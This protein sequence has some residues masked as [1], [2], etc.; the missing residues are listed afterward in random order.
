MAFA[1]HN[2]DNPPASSPLV[3]L[4]GTLCDAR[5]FAPMLQRLPP[6][7]VLH[8]PLDGGEDV[9]AVASRILDRAPPTFALMGF[10]L[11][12]IVALEILRRAPDRLIGLALI[13][14]TARPVPAEQR[15]A[16]RAGNALAAHER[17]EHLI[18][19]L[20]PE[21]VG[22]GS[23]RDAALRRTIVAMAT[24]CGRE[25]L[26]AQTEIMLSRGDRRATLTRF[27]KPAL[28]LAGEEDALCTP[29]LQREMADALPMATLAL[30]PG[31]GHFALL[32]QP[33]AVAVHVVR[34][35]EQVDAWAASS[36]LQNK[37]AE[38]IA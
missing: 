21:Y 18:D 5:V 2:A 4:P 10:S 23:R 37:Q 25:A 17:P 22:A 11:G 35:L 8:L 28:V 26:A 19:R 16:R 24:D 7:P 20:W 38:E 30:I 13:D 29:A 27:A 36:M 1:R 33:A 14:S 9:G 6:R 32:E 12:G 31:A 15:E 34:W 3:L